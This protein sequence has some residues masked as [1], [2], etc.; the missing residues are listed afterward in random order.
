LTVEPLIKLTKKTL[1]IKPIPMEEYTKNSS[2][3][4]RLIIKW[5]THFIV[6]SLAAIILSTLFSSEWF[7]KPR[8]KSVATVYPANVIPYGD[9]SNTEQILQV[10]QSTEIRDAIVT[11]FNLFEHY[12]ITKTENSAQS[13]LIGTYQNFVSIT[14]TEFESV[15][16]KVTDTD[17]KLACDMANEIIVQLNN[18]I[19][20]LHKEKAN[21]VVQ[22]LNKQLKLESSQLDSLNKGMQELRSKYQILDYD[23]QV[24][25]ASKEYVKTKNSNASSLMKSLE[26]KGGEY[27]QYKKIYDG[28]I[29]SYNKT[30]TEY[31]TAMKELNKN[32]TYTYVVSP[33]SVSDKKAY[34]IRWLIVS[35]STFSANFLLLI[36]V[37]FLNNKKKLIV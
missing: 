25:E 29:I 15:D 18:K 1:Q 33:P 3:L 32:F 17:P 21:E 2:Y 19:S 12:G 13:K 22:L 30:R 16:I 27:Y 14:K 36:I 11:K 31:N 20:K 9:E 24:K 28:L 35:I 10:L 37:I 6:V 8:F 26:E 23:I 4:V 7:I 5:K 34:P